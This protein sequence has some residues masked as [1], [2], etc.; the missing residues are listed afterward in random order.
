MKIV[1][2][3]IT[4]FDC[5]HYKK[6]ESPVH[7]NDAPNFG[8]HEILSESEWLFMSQNQSYL[9]AVII[10]IGLP[11]WCQIKIDK[12]CKHQLVNSGRVPTNL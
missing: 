3:Q 12:K 11:C 8:M 1:L 10:L 2:V 6:L 7:I 5:V 9:P 4:G